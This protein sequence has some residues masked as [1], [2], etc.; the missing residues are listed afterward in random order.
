[1]TTGDAGT[2]AVVSEDSTS[3]ATNKILNF[4]IPKGDPGASGTSADVSIGTTTTG[5]A[6]TSA[7]VALDA[8]STPTNKVLNFTLPRG[9]VGTTGAG[10]TIA[11]GNV[12]NGT[13]GGTPSVTNS[14][15]SQAAVLDFVLPLGGSDDSKLNIESDRNYS[16]NELAFVFE[17]RPSSTEPAEQSY[18]YLDGMSNV[19]SHHDLVL[20]FRDKLETRLSA[21]SSGYTRQSFTYDNFEFHL[22]FSLGYV[23]TKILSHIDFVSGEPNAPTTA[24]SKMR[25]E[26][27]ITSGNG[28][29]YT[30]GNNHYIQFTLEPKVRGLEDVYSIGNEHIYLSRLSDGGKQVKFDGRVG[31]GLSG[32]PAHELDISGTCKAN[33]GIYTDVIAGHRPGQTWNNVV[34]LQQAKFVAATTVWTSDDVGVTY[35]ATATTITHSDTGSYITQIFNESS[36]VSD[37]RINNGYL[38][39]YNGWPNQRYIIIRYTILNPDIS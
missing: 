27:T 20:K 16:D 24:L 17:Y 28:F 39:Y 33:R 31:I 34:N 25:D 35:G 9:D 2:L 6:G 3:S 8:S 37:F 10:S 11:I 13:V 38:Q 12:S 1:M 21:Y 15:T 36:Y 32:S 29:F 19:K 26:F 7:S 30:T 22:E 4:T 5:Q 14:G 23:G 18:V